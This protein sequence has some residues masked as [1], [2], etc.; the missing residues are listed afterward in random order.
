[1]VQRILVAALL[2]TAA[3]HAEDRFG[4]RGQVVPFGNVSYFHVSFAN[5]SG[6]IFDLAPGALWFFTEAIAVGGAAHF[7]Y[8]T[9]FGGGSS[10]TEGIEPQIGIAVPLGERAAFFPRVGFAFNWFSQ[11]TGPAGLAVG[12]SGLL[13]TMRA[14]AP[15]LYF[16]V[17]HFFLGFGPQFNVD[18]ASD[19]AAKQT[20][21]GV[22]TEIGG[23][24]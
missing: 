16:P 23:Y 7:S 24:F 9:G 5:V 21:Y 14:F 18:L 1:M 6:D 4:Q 22:T 2:A 20:V 3:V 19:N 15:V 12:P 13:L 11:Q 10:H 17:P 8:A